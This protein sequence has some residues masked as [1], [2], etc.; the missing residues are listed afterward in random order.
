M[1]NQPT[2]GQ[3]QPPSSPPRDSLHDDDR[4]PRFQP[5]DLDS[6]V[7]AI[8]LQRLMDEGGDADLYDVVMDLNLAFEGGK[9]AAREQAIVRIAESMAQPGPGNG[10][11]VR[12]V[13][14]GTNS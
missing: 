12:S 7:V 1:E 14:P 6:G 8:P 3:R 11:G 4:R 2:D 13:A 10:G 9:D 5:E